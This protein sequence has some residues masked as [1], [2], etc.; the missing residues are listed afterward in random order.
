MAAQADLGHLA[1]GY[2]YARW[3]VARE[4]GGFDDE[5]RLGL[6]CSDEVEHRFVALKGLACPV[7]ADLAEEAVLDA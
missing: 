5:A 6:R 4:E 7:L 2:L 1:V 3:V